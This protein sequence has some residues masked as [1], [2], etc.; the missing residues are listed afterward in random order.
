ME[1]DNISGDSLWMHSEVDFKRKISYI[2]TKKFEDSKEVIKSR[3]SKS[4]SG[5]KRKGHKKYSGLQN[6]MQRIKCR[7]TQPHTKPG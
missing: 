5:Q 4:D 2:E 6:N 1:H 3:K 7:A